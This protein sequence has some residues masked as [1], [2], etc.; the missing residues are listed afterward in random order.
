MHPAGSE[1]NMSL[2]LHF[3]YS[4]SRKAIRSCIDECFILL[5]LVGYIMRLPATDFKIPF[6]TLLSV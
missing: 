6:K 1:K 2:P 4:R 5:R 3:N